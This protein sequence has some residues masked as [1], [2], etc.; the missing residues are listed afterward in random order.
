M[1]KSDSKR[2]KV[3]LALGGGA[4]R[5]LAH[6]GVLGILER[7]GIPVDMIAGTSIGAVIGAMYAQVKDVN[8]I[9]DLALDLSKKKLS[10]WLDPTLPKSG[11]LRG[12]MLENTV[13]S[14]IGGI[15]FN[16]LRI[17]FACVATDIYS[18]EEVVIKE[19]SVW[20]GIR[21]SSSI[22][23]LFTVVKWEGRYLVD[24]GLVNPVPVSIVRD[25]GADFIIAVNVNPDIRASDHTYW[26]GG[27]NLDEPKEPNIISVMMQSIYISSHSLAKA[28]LEGADVVIEPWVAHV[29]PI[30]F[31]QVEECV[32]QG[33]LVAQVTLPD[34]KERY[35]SE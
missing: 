30:D 34:I 9:K 6:I 15:N 2:K 10:F 33:E 17:P 20:D 5:G 32:L 16:D 11:L 3:G 27:E 31:S 19:R 29:N 12:R 1:K 26:V 13:K 18:G 4:A 22:P 21:A 7:E 8:R 23:G 24:G 35:H 25:M 14:V 28:S